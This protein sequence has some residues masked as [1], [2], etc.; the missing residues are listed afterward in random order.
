MFCHNR[1]HPWYPNC[2]TTGRWPVPNVS[3]PMCDH[4]SDLI[5]IFFKDTGTALLPLL[6]PDG[7]M[8]MRAA[9]SANHNT[10]FLG[11]TLKV[12]WRV[13][14]LKPD[15]VRAIWSGLE[16]A[17]MRLFVPSLPLLAGSRAAE[18]NVLSAKLNACTAFFLSE[19]LLPGRSQ[20]EHEL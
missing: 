8:G 3:R 4:P 17:S 14:T 12:N 10:T 1:V 18:V 5:T 13:S 15:Y 20:N 7:Q 11:E 2:V 6:D 9:T 19:F 16:L